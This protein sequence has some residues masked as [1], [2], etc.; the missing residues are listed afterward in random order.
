MVMPDQRISDFGERIDGAR[1]HAH[2][3]AWAA[4]LKTGNEPASAG[5]A[6]AALWPI[7]PYER[8]I[9]DGTDPWMAA[10]AHALRDHSGKAPRR[11][12]AYTRWRTQALDLRAI[13]V[14]ALTGDIPTEAAHWIASH[15]ALDGL[16]DDLC[17]RTIAYH[18]H[19]HHAPIA[20]LRFEQRMRD[21]DTQ[22]WLAT[23]RCGAVRRISLECT[24]Q[25]ELVRRA[26][27]GESAPNPDN[28]PARARFE[29][30]G[31]A[32]G[33]QAWVAR[34]GTGGHALLI[35]CANTTEAHALIADDPQACEDAWKRW[36]A[37]PPMRPARARPRTGP[38]PA[39]GRVTPERFSTD[40]SLRGVQFGNWVGYARR[41]A[42]LARAYMAL[43]DLAGVIGWP[44]EQLA[45]DATL[46][47][48]FG[49]RGNGG[50]RAGSAHYE[51]ARHVINLTRNAGAGSLA[52][53]WWHALDHHLA[54]RAGRPG[55]A[56]EYE[57]GPV[58]ETLAPAARL[59]QTVR[60]CA[61]VAR[62][63]RLDKR[64][65]TPYWATMREMTARSFERYVLDALA[66]REICNDYLAAFSDED[67]WE[68]GVSK[69][70]GLAETYPYPNDDEA[71]KLKDHYTA[72]LKSARR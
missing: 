65:R 3:K 16:G 62:S 7:P 44:I 67:A 47:L 1:K 20:H 23:Q 6:L 41:E 68:E 45:L 60:G 64:R 46:G 38:E 11:A 9:A 59:A 27:T 24:S 14:E 71:A 33:A 28:G 40:I 72:V 66:K 5:L 54:E 69:A 51:P 8:L 48:A 10:F 52:H 4:N 55:Y 61:I 43:A 17:T 26:G 42:E 13:A 37:V 32:E 12:S 2:A 29:V 63:R 70:I 58:P 21:D 19:G 31:P 56:T 35:E 34:V 57:R 25:L 39:I 53:E 50:V 18:D 30:R 36:R 15:P 49:A 22:R